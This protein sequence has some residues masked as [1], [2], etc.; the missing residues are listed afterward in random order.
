MICIV[1]HRAIMWSNT[2]CNRGLA[3]SKVTNF[4]RYGI[5]SAIPFSEGEAATGNY[6]LRWWH[7][8]GFSFCSPIGIIRN[9]HAGQTH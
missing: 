9:R 7:N 3:E 4:E 2:S 6:H 8:M 1:G 5:M